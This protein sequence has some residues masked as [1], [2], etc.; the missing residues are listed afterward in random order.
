MHPRYALDR[1]IG[2]LQS[3]RG[4]YGEGK[5]LVTDGTQTLNPR[6][7]SPQEVAIPTELPPLVG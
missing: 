5:I 2:G 6:S 1:G 4:R 7:C 3:R